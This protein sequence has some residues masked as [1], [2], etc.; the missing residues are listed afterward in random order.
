MLILTVFICRS[1]RQSR[2]ILKVPQ[3]TVGSLV[4]VVVDILVGIYASELRVDIS[5]LCCL[6]MH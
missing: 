4:P 2:D 6:Y 5:D 3:G 1:V